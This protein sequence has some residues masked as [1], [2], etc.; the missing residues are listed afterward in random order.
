VLVDALH[1]DSDPN[2]SFAPQALHV[3][4]VSVASGK[5]KASIAPD[6]RVRVVPNRKYTGLIVV[7][8]TIADVKGATATAD[9][10]VTVTA[11]PVR[12]AR[13]ITIGP[14]DMA[15]TIHPNADVT[16]HGSL[17]VSSVEF[18][19]H[20]VIVRV[21]H[22]TL[23]LNRHDLSRGSVTF[24]Y[25]LVGADGVQV[26]VTETVH[27]L[28]RDATTHGDTTQGSALPHTGADVVPASIL[29]VALTLLGAMVCL[30]ARR[31]D[32]EA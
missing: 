9:I 24:D 23:V 14:D 13:S 31:R 7:T 27:L 12:L 26:T 19:D 10:T 5:G 8:Y 4:R 22:N 30:L 28:G 20:G 15:A 18:P 3:T 16:G 2:S 32:E 11:A 25:V 17:T 21:E 6:G 29:G 1:N